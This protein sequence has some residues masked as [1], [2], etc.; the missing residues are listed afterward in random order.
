[1]Q[2]K[3]REIQALTLLIAAAWVGN[4]LNIPLFFGVYFLF[5]SIA[6]WLITSGPG[7]P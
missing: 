7:A 4:Y 6:V 3:A 2:M 1:M 5:G